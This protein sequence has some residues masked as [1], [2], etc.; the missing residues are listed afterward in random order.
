ML[1]LAS[2]SAAAFDPLDLQDLFP[3]TTDLVNATQSV[4]SSISTLARS[5]ADDPDAGAAPLRQQLL[6]IRARLVYLL[7]DVVYAVITHTSTLIASGAILMSHNIDREPPEDLLTSLESQWTRVLQACSA[8]R[9]SLNECLS[10]WSTFHSLLCD[11]R[12]ARARHPGPVASF[13]RALGVFGPESAAP[14]ATSEPPSASY[15]DFATQRALESMI[16]CLTQ[17]ESFWLKR[18]CLF[19]PPGDRIDSVRLA[20]SH[21]LWAKLAGLHPSFNSHFYTCIDHLRIPEP[22]IS[23]YPTSLSA[24]MKSTLAWRALLIA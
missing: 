1:E 12:L 17:I 15:S 6:E 11:Y 4:A 13:L 22:I 9:D 20:R 24:T 21:Q 18:Q 10:A 16:E 2:P 8:N 19:S 23:R 5:L 14:S 3:L 7:A